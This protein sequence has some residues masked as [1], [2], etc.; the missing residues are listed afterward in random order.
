[1]SETKTKKPKKKKVTMRDVTDW[2][3]EYYKVKFLPKHFFVHLS[4]IPQGTYPGLR[5]AIPYDDLLDMWQRKTS[6]LEKVDLKNRQKGRIMEDMARIN[7]DLAIILSKYDSYC[8]WKEEQEIERQ[9]LITEHT[10]SSIDYSK[11]DSR[12]SDT[13][14]S[15]PSAISETS[16]TDITELLDDIYN[17]L[18]EG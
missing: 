13:D 9:R 18:D 14:N 4:K 6:Y 5:Q 16:D 2:I 11:I 1:M 12:I 17:D 15:I 10:Q 3:Y 7:Y 8:A